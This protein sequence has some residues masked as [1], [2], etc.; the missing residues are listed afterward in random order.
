MVSIKKTLGRR[1]GGGSSSIGTSLILKLISILF[2]LPVLFY[3]AIIIFQLS[4]L[5]SG[6]YSD[7]IFVISLQGT[8]NA[9]PHNE[10][11]LDLF[12]EAWRTRCRS[13]PTITLC[14]G[15]MDERRGYGLTMSWRNCLKEARNM[16]LD[17]TIIF[18]DDARLFDDKTSLNFCDAGRRSS[19]V[20]SNL[21]RNTFIAFLGGH[22]WTYANSNQIWQPLASSQLSRFVET[23]FS[24][25]TYGFAVPRRSLDT[26]LET[27]EEDLAL[28][29]VDE[30]GIRQTEFLSP[31]RSWY[32]KA[33]HI[34]KR[35]YAIHP[36]AVWHEGGYSNTWK[37]DRESITGKEEDGDE[38]R[39]GVGIRGVAA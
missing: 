30:E 11:R 39:S 12:K 38:N 34:G 2:L 14:P 33:R 37:H 31:E 26:L 29:S 8:P 17:V 32:T 1:E 35:I 13:E 6:P 27:I 36:L 20:W 9:D 22:T 15:V 19:N 5:G 7:H 10:G 21:P 28:G 24:F 4:S 16:N 25:G 23:K 3:T 18:E